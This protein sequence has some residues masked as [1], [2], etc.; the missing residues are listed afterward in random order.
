MTYI[1]SSYYYGYVIFHSVCVADGRRG[2]GKIVQI[3]R[4]AC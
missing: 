4:G 1:Q 2:H 3:K